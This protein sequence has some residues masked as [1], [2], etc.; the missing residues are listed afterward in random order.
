MIH[1][2]LFLLTDQYPYSLKEYPIS[3]S[4]RHLPLTPQPTAVC[5]FFSNPVGWKLTRT[6]VSSRADSRTSALIHLP[7]FIQQ[8]P[9]PYQV[10]Y[11]VPTPDIRQQM[12][13]GLSSQEVHIAGV[14]QR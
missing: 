2:T 10:S 12:R 14:I 6:P 11:M 3:I 4:I 8:I 5:L 13:Q 9:S 1:N 7:I